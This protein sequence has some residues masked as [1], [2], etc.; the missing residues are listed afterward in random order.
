MIIRKKRI[1]NLDRYIGSV[2]VGEEIIISIPLSNINRTVLTN[3]GFS[4]NLVHGETILP[5]GIGPITKFNSSGKYQIHRDEPKETVYRQA[6]WTRIEY[7]GKDNPVEVTNT[8]DI[9]YK[10][11]PRTLIYPPSIELNIST[12]QN[13]NKLIISPKFKYEKDKEV[14]IIHTI[15]MFLEIFQEA[16]IIDASL[17]GIIQAPIIRLNWKVLPKGE[18]PWQNIK[19]IVHEIIKRKPKTTRNVILNRIETINSYSPDFVAVGQG[20]FYGY[21][22]FGFKNK[23]I[24]IMESQEINN[25]TYILDK[26]WKHISQLSKAEILNNNLHK[27]RIVHRKTWNDKI[28]LILK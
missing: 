9:P 1:R 22:V 20:G 27:D 2:K 15:N 21:L 11:Y 17:N 6:E 5:K 18:M 25:A 12:D 3:I 26:S 14:Q 23:Q 16:H 4:N 13:G 24:Y 19:G 7:H 28:G 10:R 8:V